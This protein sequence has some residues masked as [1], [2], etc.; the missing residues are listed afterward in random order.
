M[1]RGLWLHKVK[2]AKEMDSNNGVFVT[3]FGIWTEMEILYY[4]YLGPC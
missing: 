3:V 2:V 1:D 4:V